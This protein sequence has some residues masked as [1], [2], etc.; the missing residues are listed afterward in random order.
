[1]AGG[2]GTRFQSVTKDIPKPMFPILGKPILEYQ[3]ES[4]KQSGI[5]DITIVIG[6]LGNV[7]QKY[8]GNGNKFAVSIDYIVENTPMGTAGALFY[9]KNKIHDD[10]ILVFGDLILD[11]DWNRFMDF[12]K[13]HNAVIT[14]YGHPN[15][16]PDDSDIIVVNQDNKV[17]KIEP[18]N[19]E[20]KFFYHNFVNA[21]LYCVNPK[22]LDSLL[23]AEKIDLEKKL[24]AD[25]IL[26]GTVYAYRSTEY[27]K[28]IGTPDRLDAVSWDVKN[29]IVASRNLKNK[30]KAIF[31]DEECIIS[32]S[33]G[34]ELISSIATAIQKINKSQYLSIVITNK[35]AMEKGR[36]TLEE[37][38]TKLGRYG[39]YVDDF[40]F[41][42]YYSKMEL[43]EYAAEK[44]NIDLSESWYIGDKEVDSKTGINTRIKNAFLNIEKRKQNKKLDAIATYGGLSLEETVTKIL[45]MN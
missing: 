34:F 24:I 21:G 25:Q 35:L 8:F 42:Q 15:A 36:C 37:L 6:H 31:V 38:E 2:K 23:V 43:L 33:K 26:A 28:D 32:V 22:L 1:M 5:T 18:K 16:H 17:V 12:H 39:A 4:L 7:I 30:Q 44:Y 11:V 40:S 3:I 29:G 14:L 45:Q 13:T 27:I 10:F 20:R 41:C 19:V 9:L